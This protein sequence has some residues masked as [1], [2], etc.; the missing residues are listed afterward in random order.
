MTHIGGLN[1]E[2][3]YFIVPVPDGWTTYLPWPNPG[4]NDLWFHRLDTFTATLR[5]RR[6]YRPIRRSGWRLAEELTIGHDASAHHMA[7][8]SEPLILSEIPSSWHAKPRLRIRAAVE[9]SAVP[10]A[11]PVVF[12]IVSREDFRRRR[13]DR[14]TWPSH[15]NDST[16]RLAGGVTYENRYF[17]TPLPE[18]WRE[19]DPL[20]AASAE[21]VW[22]DRQDEFVAALNG[23]WN[24]LRVR[25][26]ALP[27]VP[28][29][30]GDGA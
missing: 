17:I 29:C 8:T 20:P 11:A 13:T 26:R 24:R 10:T 3:L 2:G 21:D 23:P 18:S 28:F 30:T 25:R 12:A 5:G 16:M 15:G 1:Y 4:P 19:T 9:E 7:L 6:C 22:F 27:T 14:L